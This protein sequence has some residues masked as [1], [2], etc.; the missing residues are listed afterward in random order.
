MIGNENTG[1]QDHDYELQRFWQES[2]L[3]PEELKLAERRIEK[4]ITEAVWK[5]RPQRVTAPYVTL[6]STF[7][8]APKYRG[9]REILRESAGTIRQG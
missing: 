9:T 1:L 4:T 5:G 2:D 8:V 7:D 3:A 6:F